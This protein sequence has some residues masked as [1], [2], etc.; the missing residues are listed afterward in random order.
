MNKH[1]KK[2]IS[3]LLVS[4]MLVS[5]LAGCGTAAPAASATAKASESV[6]A[7]ES[8]TEKAPEQAG[9]P[10][11]VKYYMLSGNGPQKNLPAVVE[12]INKYLTDSTTTNIQMDVQQ[13]DWSY[14]DKIKLIISSGEKFDLAFT[15]GWWEYQSF[16]AKGA[17]L[18]LNDLFTEYAPKT[19]AKLALA[20]SEGPKVKGELYGIPTEKDMAGN[21]GFVFN[22]KL[23]TKYGFD[24][25]TIKKWSDVTPW[26]K[27]IKENEPDIL[28]LLAGHPYFQDA[29]WERLG[30]DGIGKTYK[31]KTDNTVYNQY[32]LPEAV[33]NIKLSH[34]WYVAG[35]TNQDAAVDNSSDPYYKSGNW[36]ANEQQ[37]KP[38][39]ADE[40]SIGYGYKL[41]QAEICE[42]F[43][44]TD[45]TMGS[46][47]SISVTSPDKGVGAM[48][49]IE[50]LHTDKFVLNTLKYGVEGIDY[51][52]VSD[53]VI[54]FPEGV[55]SSSSGYS[56]GAAWMVGDQGLDYL[57]P[58]ENPKKWEL[59]M[60]FNN[61]A[62]VTPF[63]GFSFDGVPVK[64]QLAAVAD[65]L[66]KY[67]ALAI[68]TSLDPDETLAKFLGELKSAGADEIVAAK[69]SQLD[70]WLAAKK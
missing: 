13:F 23:I 6:A 49:F 51:V 54:D 30:G 44:G 56:T 48:K 36:F 16:V 43:S 9:E 14:L 34:D 12:T 37:L 29:Y 57:Y 68:G 2:L 28:P 40:M 63:L 7:G 59:M 52:K 26:L 47:L 24:V 19:K 33:E 10:Y 1:M 17:F 67:K 39:K 25:S 20:Y 45:D 11:T 64:T 60:A 53:N 62:T 21:F 58:S 22:E 5:A 31:Y 32:T 3:L 27:K 50:L 65:V 69:Q 46:M 15:A 35:Y 70:A 38:G 18:P 61:S 4:L 8:A 41:V 55:L 66:A 42:P